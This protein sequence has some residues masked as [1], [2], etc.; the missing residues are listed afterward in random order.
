MQAFNPR[1]HVGRQELTYDHIYDP[2]IGLAVQR[3]I[4]VYCFEPVLQLYGFPSEHIRRLRPQCR[5]VLATTAHFETFLYR[6]CR[7]LEI[8]FLISITPRGVT[9]SPCLWRPC[10]LLGLCSPAV[11]AFNRFPTGS[12]DRTS[13]VLISG[14]T[15][16]LRDHG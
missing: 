15:D 1:F 8:E 7:H 5:K 3:Q 6:F 16:V 14:R 12:F 13:R 11:Y 9:I 2:V 10:I 4:N